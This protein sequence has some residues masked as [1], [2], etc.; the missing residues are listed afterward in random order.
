MNSMTK[1]FEFDPSQWVPF[2]DKK[3][4]EENWDGRGLQEP[5]DKQLFK[6]FKIYFP[7]AR[8]VELLKTYQKP[9]GN[10]ALWNMV[11]DQLLKEFKQ[12]VVTLAENNIYDW[13]QGEFSAVC[14][15]IYHAKQGRFKFPGG[16]YI[17]DQENSFEAFRREMAAY[18]DRK[19]PSHNLQKSKNEH[20][21]L[22]PRKKDLI[23]KIWGTIPGP[24]SCQ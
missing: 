19:T 15:H 18:F 20:E 2:K 24:N 11:N 16:R 1:K 9:S 14:Y 10:E 6:F 3:E 7:Y 8:L 17:K 23:E 5:F 21:K 4:I 22:T 13:C 12:G